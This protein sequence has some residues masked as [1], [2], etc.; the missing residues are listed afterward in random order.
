VSQKCNQHYVIIRNTSCSKYANRFFH[1]GKFCFEVPFCK[2]L[3][4]RNRAVDFVEICNI[5]V[6]KAIIKAAKR[7]IKSDEM[8]RS[9]SDLN[10]GVTFLEHS[11]YFIAYVLY[12]WPTTSGEFFSSLNDSKGQLSAI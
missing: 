10:F 11:V 7:I 12:P 4:L 2:K 1:I 8:C 9:Y 3:L 5:C 6:R